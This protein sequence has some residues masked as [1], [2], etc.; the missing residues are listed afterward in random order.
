MPNAS[1]QPMSGPEQ[2]GI[3]QHHRA[4]GT[5][6]RADPEAAV[7]ER[8]VQPRIRAGISSWIAE[9]MAVYSPP[10]PAPVK[11]AEEGEAP[12]VPGKRRGGGGHEV[13][14]ERDVEQP[15]AAEPVGQPAEEGGAEHRAGQ[16]GAA[17]KPDL[18]GRQPQ[19]RA[20][21]QGAGQRAGERDLEA[22]EDPGDAERDDDERSGSGST[23][24]GRA[25]PGCLSPP[26]GPVV[27]CCVARPAL[28]A[29]RSR[30]ARRG[31]STIT[32]AVE[33][34]N[35][36]AT[37]A[38]RRGRYGMANAALLACAAPAETTPAEMKRR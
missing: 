34:P 23:A 12:E 36:S 15:L 13:D 10:M 33:C 9:L 28:V 3:E 38:L 8:S 6:C 5:Q 16:I 26:L 11:K 35:P 24:G 18:G 32:S 14:A 25:A 7:D 21:L 19:R 20:L 27:D 31:P 22:I 37:A 4:R 30:A 1:R 29:F 2:A 17:R